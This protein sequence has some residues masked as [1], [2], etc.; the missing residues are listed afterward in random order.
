M[1]GSF[2]GLGKPRKVARKKP[3]L[4]TPSE[5]PAAPDRAPTGRVARL[6]WG[7]LRG[8]FPRTE[9]PKT[10]ARQIRER[11][12]TVRKEIVRLEESGHVINVDQTGWY[13]AWADPSLL[14]FAERPEPC[15]HGLQLECV[16]P[17]SGGLGV[18]RGGRQAK[19]AGYEARGWAVD[20]SNDQAV[21]VFWPMGRRL[22]MRAS[23]TGSLQINIGATRAPVTFAD[24]PEF[25]AEVRGLCL[26]YG[27]DLDAPTSRLVNVEFNA[28]WRQ[29][30]LAGLKRMKVS[31][32]ST[33][34][35][36]IYQKHRDALRLELRVSPKELTFNEAAASLIFLLEYRPALPKTPEPV[37]AAP[38]SKFHDPS[39]M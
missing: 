13:R 9:Q 10:I 37:V 35:G 22:E 8:I 19:L 1:T 3:H 36:Q 2:S 17:L 12:P 32:V 25:V 14:S 31:S 38:S 39:V 5:P 33:A 20:D 16:V 28:D 11:P 21:R 15:V 30:F 27:I 7:Y 26:A 4:S 34:W 6:I 24:W 29:F 23:G 18:P